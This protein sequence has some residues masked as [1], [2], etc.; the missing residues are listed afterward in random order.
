MNYDTL[1]QLASSE[2]EKNGIRHEVLGSITNT[3]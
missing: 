1:V 2:T 3:L